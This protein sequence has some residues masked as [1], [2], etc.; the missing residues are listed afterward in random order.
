MTDDIA[1]SSFK[2]PPWWV[3]NCAPDAAGEGIAWPKVLAEITDY[4][5]FLHAL[6]A[7]ANERQI[8]ISSENTH[9]VAGL[10]DRRMTQLLSLRTLHNIQSVR[11]IGITS[12]GPVFGVLG[13]K[14]IMVED[15]EAIKRFGSRISRRNG[16]LAHG[17]AI[18]HTFSTKFMQ[19]IGK[20]GAQVRW[21]KQRK[22]D[23]VAR[24][25]SAKARRAALIRWSDVK[26]AVKCK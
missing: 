16:N 20:K 19:K 8:A 18:T 7:R 11:R 22:R 25:K 13:V 2:P 17:G 4:A 15:E 10:S 9:D 14:F 26:E 6:R 23:A 5:S 1:V 12:M 3:A 24:A 21:K